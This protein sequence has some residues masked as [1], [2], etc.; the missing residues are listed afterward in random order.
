MINVVLIEPEIPVNTGNIMRT[1]VATNTHLHL[2]EP[3]GF[4]LDE[5]SIKR[6]GTNYVENCNYTVYKNYA[7]FMKKNSGGKYYFL[8]RYGNKP[9]TNNDF[10]N[11]DDNIYVIFGKES[12]GIPHELLKNNI[13]NCFRIPMSED[14]RALNVSNTVAIV[15]Y[16]ILRQQNYNDL[17]F[18]E[19]QK[20]EDFLIK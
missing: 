1:C 9:H 10:S 4:S 6:S 7:E 5:K 19:T 17:S 18:V 14:V 2:I 8:T 20:G 11:S 12:T 3:L 16:E 13:D 15:V